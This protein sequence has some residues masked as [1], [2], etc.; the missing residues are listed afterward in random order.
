MT[1]WGRAEV[2]LCVLN[3]SE[4]LMKV[5]SHSLMSLPVLR[6]TETL[7]DVLGD[8]K[9]SEAFIYYVLSTSERFVKIIMCPLTF[10]GVLRHYEAF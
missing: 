7:S 4:S 10:L 8:L 1:S 9:P 6:H 5:P 2:F 3:C